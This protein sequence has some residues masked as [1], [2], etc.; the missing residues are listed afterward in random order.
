MRL[1][2]T[3]AH[4][5]VVVDELSRHGTDA[6]LALDQ[7]LDRARANGLQWLV[8][9]SVSLDKIPAV[10]EL[11]EN[12]QEVY[13]AVAIHPCDVQD[14][15]EADRTACF[16]QLAG[17]LSHDKVV[18]LGETGLDYY[19]DESTKPVQ[20]LFIRR[21]FELARQYRLPMVLHSRS[22]DDCSKACNDDLYQ[23]A[24]EYPDVTG[25][26]HCF[27]GNADMAMRM[28]DAGYY[29]SFAGN[30]T[31]KKACNLH[32]AA[33]VVPLDRLL[34][35]TDSPYLSPVPCRGQSPNEPARV[36]HVAEFIADLRQTDVATIAQ[37]TTANAHR[38]FGIPSMVAAEEGVA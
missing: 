19:W 4:L 28:V 36:L 34:I 23:L 13:A 30:V 3:H 22:K 17:Y 18:A 1:V 12:H 21:F 14:I 24:C 9:P 10:L 35:E 33:K 29:I 38:F 8:V 32:E 31:F 20:W 5:D 25:V 26:M 15:A 7:V 27:S 6:Q 2:D 11:A 37:A 16:E